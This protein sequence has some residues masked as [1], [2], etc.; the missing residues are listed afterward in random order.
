MVESVKRVNWKMLLR[1]YE[2]GRYRV[3]GAKDRQRIKHEVMETA[4][5]GGL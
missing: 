5:L 2:E 3:V 4:V 1:V